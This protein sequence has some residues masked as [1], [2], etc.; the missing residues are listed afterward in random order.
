M[1]M[2]LSQRML[3]NV[4]LLAKVCPLTFVSYMGLMHPYFSHG[5]V[6]LINIL[7]DT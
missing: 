4:S 7:S 6:F 1:Y 5:F 3:I 2:Y